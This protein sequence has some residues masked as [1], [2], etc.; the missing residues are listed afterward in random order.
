MLDYAAN[1]PQ[2]FDH[3]AR[4]ASCQVHL[5]GPALALQAAILERCCHIGMVPETF[6][7]PGLNRFSS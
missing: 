4:L 1:D 6:G 7:M 3:L 2:R 5:R